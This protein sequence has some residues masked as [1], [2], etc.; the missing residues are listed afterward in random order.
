MLL[1]VIPPVPT[2][3]PPSKVEVAVEL[4]VSLPVMVNA[5]STVEDASERKPPSSVERPPT[6]KEEEAD[7]APPTF[8]FDV[9]VEDAWESRPEFSVVR[10]DTAKE[11]EALSA[12][13]TFRL[14][15]KVE[16]AAAISPPLA[17]MEKRV[18]E[19]LDNILN[20]VPLCPSCSLSVSTSEREDVAARVSTEVSL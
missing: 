4:D 16:D 9:K 19:A 3:S 14:D 10:P 13:V 15:A 17:S 12:P 8:R 18:E 11:E 6:A 2:H 7:S 20:G 5:P 1:M